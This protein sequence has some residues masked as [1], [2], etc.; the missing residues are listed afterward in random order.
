MTATT[1]ANVDKAPNEERADWTD[2]AS[3]SCRVQSDVHK[4]A[5]DVSC[6]FIDDLSPVAFV[7]SS[8]LRSKKNTA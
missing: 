7:E 1:K 2:M 8:L 4:I 3:C 6:P 5:H